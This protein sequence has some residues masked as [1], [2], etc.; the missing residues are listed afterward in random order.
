M[1]ASGLLQP[2]SNR[3]CGTCQ[4]EQCLG[5]NGTHTGPVAELVQEPLSASESAGALKFEVEGIDGMR[6]GRG[7]CE[8]TAILHDPA[9]RDL[10]LARPCASWQHSKCESEG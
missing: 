8:R 1:F 5:L 4:L 7:L 10:R 9:E 6:S 2:Q 3:P